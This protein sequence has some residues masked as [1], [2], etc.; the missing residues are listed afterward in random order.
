MGIRPILL[1]L[2]KHRFCFLSEELVFES[3]MKDTIINCSDL[4]GHQLLCYLLEE[5]LVEKIRSVMQRMQARDF[6]DLRYLLE[7][8]G[9]NSSW[10]KKL[11]VH[12]L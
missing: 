5:L 8:Q 11:K 9:M 1:L 2:R 4:V 10:S 3:V 6:Y 12:E 7:M